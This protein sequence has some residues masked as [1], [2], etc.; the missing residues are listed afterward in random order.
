M[1]QMQ[2]V[3]PSIDFLRRMQLA[4]SQAPTGQRVGDVVGPPSTATAPI[5]NK[6]PAYVEP[7]PQQPGLF[8]VS[9]QR[10]QELQQQRQ[11]QPSLVGPSPEELELLMRMIS[12]Q[13]DKQQAPN[14]P[15]WISGVRG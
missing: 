7:P 10:N 11:Q 4:Q 5:A 2:P 1:N 9:Q 15:S 3:N 13:K 8:G 14:P 12:F 6:P